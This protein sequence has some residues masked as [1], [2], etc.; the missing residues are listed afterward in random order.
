M[1]EASADTGLQISWPAKWPQIYVIA[2]MFGV[3]IHA[4][5]T[6]VRGVWRSLSFIKRLKA[7][8][9]RDPVFRL[10]PKTPDLPCADEV[11]SGT[12]APRIHVHLSHS[13]DTGLDTS[14][15][16][17]WPQNEMQ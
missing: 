14:W 9:V 4:T 6:S 15:T 2:L 11:K 8:I 17:K 5:T 7:E 3:L 1:N 16:G 12:L 13:K 10:H